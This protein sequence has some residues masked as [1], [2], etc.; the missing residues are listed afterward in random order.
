MQNPQG[1][2]NAVRKNFIYTPDAEQFQVRDDWRHYADDINSVWRDDCDSFAAT[3]LE[4]AS[5]EGYFR[6]KL[7]MALCWT[8]TGEYHAVAI[9]DGMLLDNRNRTAWAYDSV[10]YKFHRG[11]LLSEGGVWRDM[12]N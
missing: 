4:I 6:N 12:E 9:I 7:M 11:M 2:L 5:K 10:G 1:I 3:C 8:E